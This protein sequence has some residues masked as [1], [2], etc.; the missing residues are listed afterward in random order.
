MTRRILVGI[1]VATIPVLLQAQKPS[2]GTA[3]ESLVGLTIPNV[4]V[5]AAAMV[6]GPFTPPGSQT[7]MTLPAFC[8]VEAT[9]RPASDS[10]D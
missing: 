8:R 1:A 9:A 7:A 3:C 2:P 10:E 4:V 6:T 5:N